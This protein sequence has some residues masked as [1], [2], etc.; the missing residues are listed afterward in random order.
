VRYV[1]HKSPQT[2][3]IC[4]MQC[5]FTARAECTVHCT[6]NR[7]HRIHGFLWPNTRLQ[8]ILRH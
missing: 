3:S 7:V 8:F 4:K 2:E 6:A 5:C 1:S